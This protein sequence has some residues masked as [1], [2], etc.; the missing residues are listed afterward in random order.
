MEVK[1]TISK[2]FFKDF[3]GL[4]IWNSTQTHCF[5]LP[6]LLNKCWRCCSVS[7]VT[8]AN[9]PVMCDAMMTKAL[10]DKFQNTC[11]T[12][13][14]TY[15]ATLVNWELATPVFVARPVVKRVCYTHSLICNW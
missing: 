14:P 9:V 8:R 3:K 11:C 5:S 15:H 4:E 12:H 10:E 2:D 13:A 6:G 1:T 7:N